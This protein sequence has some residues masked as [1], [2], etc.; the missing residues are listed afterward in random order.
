[1][2]GGIQNF[3]SLKRPPGEVLVVISTCFLQLVISEILDPRPIRLQAFKYKQC[4]GLLV[5]GRIEK[6]KQWQGRLAEVG[7]QQLALNANTVHQVEG[8]LK[9]CHKEYMEAK[10]RQYLLLGWKGRT[11]YALSTWN[12]Q[13]HHA[14]SEFD[15][16][17]KEQKTTCSNGKEKILNR[18]CR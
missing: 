5:S 4:E 10:D 16:V 1:M 8:L 3:V 6:Y 11:L 15:I 2:I 9:N 17:Q 18:F 7:M 14:R 13:A 12:H